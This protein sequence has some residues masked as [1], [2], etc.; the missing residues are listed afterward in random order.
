M[1]NTGNLILGYRNIRATD[2]LLPHKN[3]S[4]QDK[5]QLP[6]HRRKSGALSKNAVPEMVG[7]ALDAAASCYKKRASLRVGPTRQKAE[8]RDS[9]KPGPENAV[10]AQNMLPQSMPLWHEGYFEL[11][12]SCREVS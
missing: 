9:E 7:P 12:G 4:P 5:V 2:W 8:L 6:L 10:G 1:L 3:S 11:G